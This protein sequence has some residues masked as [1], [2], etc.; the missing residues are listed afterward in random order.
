MIHSYKQAG[1]GCTGFPE[2]LIRLD[3]CPYVRRVTDSRKAGHLGSKSPQKLFVYHLFGCQ[4][5]LEVDQSPRQQF[6]IGLI[7]H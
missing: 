6:S 2:N 1:G 3:A 4:E 7:F 5:T